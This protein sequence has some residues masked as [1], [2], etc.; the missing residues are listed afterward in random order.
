M[1]GEGRHEREGNVPAIRATQRIAMKKTSNRK[2]PF[3]ST[4]V[5]APMKITASPRFSMACILKTSRLRKV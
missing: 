5:P 2:Y 4:M 3:L 1:K